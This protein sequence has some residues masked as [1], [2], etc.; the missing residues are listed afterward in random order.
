MRSS[1]YIIFLISGWIIGF[2]P[3]SCPRLSC[4][5][6]PLDFLLICRV[7]KDDMGWSKEL[8][9]VWRRQFNDGRVPAGL[10]KE[11]CTWICGMFIVGWDGVNC[12]MEGK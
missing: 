7:T 6:D 9:Q 11:R 1:L 2:I 10:G 12:V 8:W 3:F 4:S 5:M